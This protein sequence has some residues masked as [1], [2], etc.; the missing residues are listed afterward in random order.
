M[1]RIGRSASDGGIEDAGSVLIDGEPKPEDSDE[2][3][4]VLGQVLR[5]RITYLAN[6]RE[7]IGTIGNVAGEILEMEDVME[8]YIIMEIRTTTVVEA[9]LAIMVMGSVEIVG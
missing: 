3:A 7:T 9:V 1:T 6:V 8:A 4:S 2:L 5:S